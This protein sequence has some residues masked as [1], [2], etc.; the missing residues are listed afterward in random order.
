MGNRIVR[1]PMPWLGMDTERIEGE[2]AMDM[3]VIGADLGTF[4]KDIVK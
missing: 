3:K 2:M 1:I 4:F